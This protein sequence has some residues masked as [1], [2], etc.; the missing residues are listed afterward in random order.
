MYR[1]QDKACASDTAPPSRMMPSNVLPATISLRGRL[2][3]VLA[4]STSSGLFQERPLT[5][6]HHTKFGPSLWLFCLGKQKSWMTLSPRPLS[7]GVSSKERLPLSLKA[8]MHSLICTQHSAAWDL[9]Q[10]SHQVRHH[11]PRNSRR[12]ADL[13]GCWR[14]LTA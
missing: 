9:K 13:W 7:T 8:L 2:N 14:L 3:T 10:N 4:P 12:G 11:T 5:P 1:T 6:P